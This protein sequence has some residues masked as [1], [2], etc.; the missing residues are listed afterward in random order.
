MKVSSFKSKTMVLNQKRVEHLLRIGGES[1][2]QVEEFKYFGVLFTSDGRLEWEM[3]GRIGASS[4]VMRAL[5]QSV[6]VKNKL[7]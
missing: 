5:L 2:P 6:I 7:S 1:L 3:D 4:S